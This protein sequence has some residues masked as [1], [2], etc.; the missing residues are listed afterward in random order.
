MYKTKLEATREWVK[1]FNAY[2]LG[3]IEKLFDADMDDWHEV[4]PI[5]KYSRVWSN[6]YQYCGEVTE[7]TED[8]DGNEI[9]KVELDNG[10]EI[11]TDRDDLSR[12][13]DTYFPMWGTMWAFNDSCDDYWLDEM[14]GLEAMADCGFRIYESDEFGYFF[15]IDGAGYDFYESHWIPLYEARGLKWHE[16]VA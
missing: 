6:E 10:E 14:G 16:E 2:P 7:I 13:D 8:E 3:M 15:G 12:E 1:E 9:V 5:A 4:T 11:T